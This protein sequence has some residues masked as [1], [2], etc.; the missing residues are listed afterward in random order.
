M[1]CFVFFSGHYVAAEILSQNQFFMQRI[2]KIKRS[3]NIF[4]KL[5]RFLDKDS[6]SLI[7]KYFEINLNSFIE[8]E[9]LLSM[10]EV[11]SFFDFIFDNLDQNVIVKDLKITDRGLMLICDISH[12]NDIDYLV[13]ELEQSAYIQDI[14]YWEK[15]DKIFTLK[16]WFKNQ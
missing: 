5:L 9:E 7:K 3:D 16:M 13:N 14:E 15:Q 4:V 6:I 11:K 2:E 10:D 12:V 8:S 1:M